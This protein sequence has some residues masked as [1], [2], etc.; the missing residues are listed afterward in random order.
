MRDA[1]FAGVG[2]VLFGALIVGAMMFSIW[3]QRYP[4]WKSLL[5]GYSFQGCTV[6]YIK[7]GI[8]L[9]GVV[10]QLQLESGRL[11]I[12][13]T[14]ANPCD[15]DISRLYWADELKLEGSVKSF[16]PTVAEGRLRI[17]TPLSDAIFWVRLPTKTS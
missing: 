17:E 12:D 15:G 16:R 11:S 9:E 6:N 3:R 8:E 13:I 10:R 14:D 1:L 7:D 5:R 2:G 4:R